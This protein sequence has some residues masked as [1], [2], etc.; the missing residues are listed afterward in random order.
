MSMD[1]TW[2]YHRQR[3]KNTIS[4]AQCE[5][6]ALQ[7]TFLDRI[8]TQH[9][10]ALAHSCIHDLGGPCRIQGHEHQPADSACHTAL[11][12]TALRL[13]KLYSH[14]PSSSLDCKGTTGTSALTERITGLPSDA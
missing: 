5:A 12:S 14:S 11:Q 4:H 13:S 9:Q 2:Q 10:R 1:M 3:T 6:R 8:D 7:S